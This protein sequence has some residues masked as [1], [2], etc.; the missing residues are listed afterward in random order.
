MVRS[1]S[2]PAQV[3][4][5]NIYTV[6]YNKDEKEYA[7]RLYERIGRE[8]PELRIYEFWEEAVEPHPIPMFEVNV[9][10]PHQ[11]GALFSFLAVYRGPLSWVK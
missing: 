8:F 3:A 11:L 7:R 6:Y 4:Q 10:T 5:A 2:S 9:F 1:P